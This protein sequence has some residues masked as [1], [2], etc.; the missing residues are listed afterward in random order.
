MAG[1][2]KIK[3]VYNVEIY[4]G[5]HFITEIDSFVSYDKAMNYIKESENNEHY[6]IN[7]KIYYW[8]YDDNG[9][10]YDDEVK[11]EIV[12]TVSPTEM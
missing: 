11:S 7:H 4:N 12:Y 9:K 3:D 10:Y 2:V 6:V 1:K 5:K 8:L